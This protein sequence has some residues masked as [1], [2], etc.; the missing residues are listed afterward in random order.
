MTYSCA[1]FDHSEMSL[2]DAQQNKYAT[3]FNRLENN[4][5]IL[6]IGCGWG[7]LQTMLVN[8]GVMSLALPFRKRNWIIK[9]KYQSPNINLKYVII[10]IIK[11]T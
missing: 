8:Q 6:E 9:S 4:K 3:I 7:G 2:A 11:P 1:L 5:D 10:E